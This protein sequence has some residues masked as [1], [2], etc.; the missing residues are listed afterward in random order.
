MEQV[1]NNA[2]VI[3]QVCRVDDDGDCGVRDEE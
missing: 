3:R 2:D 1:Y